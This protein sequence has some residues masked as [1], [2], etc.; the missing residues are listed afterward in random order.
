M[1]KL[2]V[3]DVLEKCSGKLI[4]G[5]EDVVLEN[6][7]K[8]T[9][10]MNSGDI[11]IGIKG[12]NFEGSSLYKKA[13]EKGALGCIL[14]DNVQID[15]DF[16]KNYPNSFIVTVKD[17]VKCLQDLAS[18]KRSLYNIPVI[19][20]TGS[21]G[22]TSTKDILASVLAKKYKVLKTEGNYNNHIG[23]PLTI[24]RLKDHDCLVIEMGMNNLGEISILSQI[25]K[26]TVGVITNVGTAHIG[27]LKSREN[28]LKAKLEILDGLA[29]EGVLVINN[30]ND[31]LNN[32]YLEKKKNYK[33]VTFGCEN[34]SDYVAKNIIS[35]KDFSNYQVEFDGNNYD[36]KINIPGNHFVLNGL[37]ALSIGQLF[38]IPIKDIK[39]GIE[40]FELTQRRMQI[41]TI[42]DVTII[43]DC[44]NAN[45]DSMKS[46]I[47]YL[48]SLNN[49]RK[50]AI[51]GSMLELGNF[52]EELHRKVGKEIF[53]N[54]IDL[55]V[56]V[57]AAAK[58][59]KEE[60][61][62]LGFNQNN[63]YYFDNN[64][65][66]ITKLA[67][68]IKANDTILI[69]ASYGMNFIEIYDKLVDILKSK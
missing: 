26:P 1:N 69:K 59:I 40:N 37:C 48:G 24:L 49:T 12:E 11:Y 56:L 68:L 33:V 20:I 51:L 57:G 23:V 31:L 52:E 36:F 14:N 53:E 15:Y 32:W 54:K 8:D 60:A 4:F 58:Y 13:L 42:N 64:L 18:Y 39:D 7:S 55:L 63:I 2:F 43:N 38:N 47:S 19:A 16:L 5:N 61:L 62:S 30:D 67:E 17:T 28:I 3:K 35:E 27:R 46:A 44:Y 34:A 41:E 45:L 29:S 10:T 9:R 50:I 25:A 66:A 6:F 22:K 65:S 21:V